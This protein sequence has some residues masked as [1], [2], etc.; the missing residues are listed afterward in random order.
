M[1][2]VRI[3]DPIYKRLQEIAVPFE[4]T[5]VTVIEKLLN[6]HDIFQKSQQ[7]SGIENFCETKNCFETENYIVIDP[8]NP[9][10]LTHSKV[11][12]ALIDDKEINK[13]NWNKIAAKVHEIAI[14]QGMSVEALKRLTRSNIK[15]GEINENGY[16]YLPEANI[17]IQGVN[18]NTAW[19]NTLHLLKHLKLPSEIYFEWPSDKEGA[20][21]PGEK[22]KIFWSPKS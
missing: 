15:Q 16:D 11:L 12:R 20:A 10:N 9:S 17:W 5:P 22:G 18:A 3:P 13:P 19:R 4:D 6:E 2:V 21:H 8:E 14:Q 7:V 1:P